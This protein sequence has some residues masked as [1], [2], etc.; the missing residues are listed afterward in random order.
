MTRETYNRALI[1]RQECDKFVPIFF[2]A[3]E[4]SKSTNEG[5]VGKANGPERSWREDT[6]VLCPLEKGWRQGG[7]DAKVLA[8][9]AL[10]TA[11][12]GEVKR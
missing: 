1:R 6:L 5:V 7:R 12:R 9:W 4:N 10:Y 8:R 11:L 3:K 2:V